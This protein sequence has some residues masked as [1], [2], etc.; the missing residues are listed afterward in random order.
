MEE[1]EPIVVF[2]GTLSIIESIMAAIMYTLTFGVICYMLFVFYALGVSMDTA[3]TIPG[4]I[5]VFFA[6]FVPAIN[7]SEVKIVKI[8]ISK[9]VIYTITKIVFY[10][11]IKVIEA[12]DFEYV[13]L[14]K[15]TFSYNVT[16]WYKGNRHYDLLG[17]NKKS[18]AYLYAKSLCKQLGVDLLDRT[19]GKP[20]WIE[21]AEL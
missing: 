20:V 12:F 3:K 16:L 4:F 17:F 10:E 9:R 13:V 5:S 15:N 19:S 1:N 7:I 2:D 18:K 14:V 11:K 8:D 6:F 21:N